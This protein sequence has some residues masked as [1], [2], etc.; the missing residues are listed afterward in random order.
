MELQ[1]NGKKD[2]GKGQLGGVWLGGKL[3]CHALGPPMDNLHS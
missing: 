3:K 1:K 2:R